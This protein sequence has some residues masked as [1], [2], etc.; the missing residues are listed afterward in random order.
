MQPMASGTSSSTIGT[1]TA[2]GIAEC[3]YRPPATAPRMA[4][5]TVPRVTQP[6]TASW[7]LA[8][9]VW[10]TASPGGSG[11]EAVRTAADCARAPAVAERP[12]ARHAPGHGPAPA[13]VA[14]RR[15]PAGR[16]R[17]GGAGHRGADGGVA[18][19]AAPRR[20]RRWRTGAHGR[21]TLAVRRAG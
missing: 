7:L 15:R 9:N 16:R 3:T 11:G 1:T 19:G 13:I 2:A 18:G 5:T 12:R 20:D 21:R 17:G 8:G 4:T 6:P 10:T 14:P